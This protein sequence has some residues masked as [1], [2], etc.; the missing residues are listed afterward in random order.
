[1]KTVAFKEL[2]ASTILNFCENLAELG[3]RPYPDHYHLACHV[4][5]DMWFRELST[6][7]QIK[8]SSKLLDIV[9]RDAK[10]FKEEMDKKNL[11]KEVKSK[12]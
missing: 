2:V 11:K 9:E 8:V 7:D 5:P 10:R 12:K 4:S 6:E 1:M 3:Y